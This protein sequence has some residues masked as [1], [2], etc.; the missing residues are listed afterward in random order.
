MKELRILT[1]SVLV[2]AAH[3]A[4]GVTARSSAAQTA[5]DP[6]A[7]FAFLAGSCW[8]GTFPQ[9]TT[10]DEHCFEWL[11]DGRFLRDTHTVR[12]AANPYSGET[13]YAWDG[14]EK[15]IVYWYIASDG[16]YSTG[17]AA[18]HGDAI[19]FPETHVSATGRRELNNTWRRTGSD[20]YRIRVT[21]KTGAGEKEL[22]SMEMRRTR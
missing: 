10:T 9:K 11:H 4:H 13:T 14:N 2:I 1:V 7:A 17:T 15:R 12:G 3:S 20:T 18:V 21:E 19:V 5:S 6:L 22:W 8:Q 16:S